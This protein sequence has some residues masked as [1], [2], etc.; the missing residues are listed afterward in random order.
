MGIASNLSKLANN[1]NSSGQ[2][3]ASDGLV[4]IPTW[5]QNT[6]GNA[7]TATN[8]DTVDGLHAANGRNNVA[9]QLVRTD[10]NGYIQCGYINSSNGN[11]GNNS[12]PSRVW[13]TNG[14]DDYLRSYLTSA[15]NAGNGITASSYAANGYI[16]LGSLYI[17][18]GYVSANATVTFPIAF[19]SVC[20][21]VTFGAAG[22][23]S[24]VPRAT[25]LTRT[26]F[27]YASAN[28]SNT[29]AYWMAV[30]Y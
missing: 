22:A 27:V 1:L 2:L 9:N 28:F 13:G 25:S 14:S 29:S 15:L 19:P 10:V 8:A 17:Q 30:G 3:D 20:T 21:S 12:S 24:G 18:W 16:K 6:T 23:G 11:E 26:N 5:N 4:N 7:A